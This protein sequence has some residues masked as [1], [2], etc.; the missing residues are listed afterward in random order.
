MEDGRRSEDEPPALQDVLDALDDPD[1]RSILREAIEPMTA[2][3]LIDACEIPKSTLY[4][5]LDLL[6]T[7]SLLRE[8]ETVNADGGRVTH[9]EC[10]FENV[11][12]SIDETGEFSI[13]VERPE[14][15][16]DERLADIWSMMG[17]EL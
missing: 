7:A 5:K 17:E 2:T 13:Q 9:Y 10:S 14:Q 15:T 3:E 12:V 4:R 8:R 1:C 6:R 11:T 16:S